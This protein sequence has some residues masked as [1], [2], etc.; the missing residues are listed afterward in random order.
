MF[1]PDPGLTS[2][3]RTAAHVERSRPPFLSTTRVWCRPSSAIRRPGAGQGDSHNRST[4]PGLRPPQS[5]SFFSRRIVHQHHQLKLTISPV[6]I[7]IANHGPSITFNYLVGL[8]YPYL[9]GLHEDRGSFLNVS[10]GTG[11]WGPPMR[12]GSHSEI[13]LLE[14]MLRT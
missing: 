14:P 2:A 10:T 12:L 7:T 3:S 9:K 5:W 1:L 8:F 4:L 11:I 6:I 13:V